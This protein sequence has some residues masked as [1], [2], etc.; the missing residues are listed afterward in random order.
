MTYTLTVLALDEHSHGLWSKDY[1][2]FF[3]VSYSAEIHYEK[4]YACRLLRKYKRKK[5]RRDKKS[6]E[7]I[8]AEERSFSNER[9][10]VCVLSSRLVPFAA[11]CIYIYIA[12]DVPE[13]FSF[14]KLILSSEAFSIAVY[15]YLLYIFEDRNIKIKM[16]SFY[17]NDDLR[18]CLFQHI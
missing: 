11:I 4:V 2:A 17:F 1:I 8:H 7:T 3:F 13:N 18:I 6:R 10:V 9:V 16:S 12:E 14:H 15:I 5:P